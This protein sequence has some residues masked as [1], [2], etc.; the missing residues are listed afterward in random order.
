[1][2]RTLLIALVLC[3]SMYLCACMQG[4]EKAEPDDASTETT[5]QADAESDG[6]SEG[7]DESE[8]F[9]LSGATFDTSSQLTG[10]A[11]KTSADAM[12]RGTSRATP[13]DSTSAQEGSS[14]ESNEIALKET[15]PYMPDTLD[16][17][18]IGADDRVTIQDT[19]AYPYSAIALI[20]A[21]GKCGCTWG[22][23]G[24]MV[25]PDMLVTASHVLVCT[26][27]HEPADFMEFYFGYHPDG[28]YA[29]A[30][31][32][33][34]QYRYGTYFPNGYDRDSLGWDF[35]VVKLLEDKVGDATGYFGYYLP[36]KDEQIDGAYLNVAG[37]R[38]GVLKTDV[39][40]AKVVDEHLF[41]HF[42][43]M[44]PGNSGCPVFTNDYFAMGINIASNDAEQTNYA[45]RLSMDLFSEM[46]KL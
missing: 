11:A 21:R 5:T 44:E 6:S 7:T 12:E 32:G 18:V 10:D 36:A 3:L 20:N 40:K 28:S 38:N 39:G 37:Y 26:K 13:V 14:N 4:A 2:K 35:G 17:I 19:Y 15:E 43:D 31:T 22:G 8:E 1:M 9:D 41:A 25:G 30:Y 45:C 34:T 29:Y 16:K 27:H 24:Y 33:T 42:A 46:D 23:T